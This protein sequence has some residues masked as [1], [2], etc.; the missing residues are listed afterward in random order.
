M[1]RSTWVEIDVSAL[2]HNFSLV[3]QHAGVP[4]CAVVKANG[5]GHGLVIAARAFAHD[6]AMLAVTRIEEARALRDAGIDARIFILAPVANPQE[7][8]DLVCEISVGSVDQIA[9]LPSDAR[10]HL[11]VDTGMGR[12][13]VEPN[14]AADAARAISARA[15]LSS[16]WTHFADAAGPSGKSQL[17][18]FAGMATS[19]RTVGI[20]VPVHA[21]N[22]AGTLALPGARFDMVRV[23]TLLYGQDPPG[24]RAP[25]TPRDP[26]AL[27]ARV[28]ALRT[29]PSGSPVGYGSEWRAKRPTR[30]ATLSVGYTDGFLL[31]PSART[32]SVRESARAAARI[33]ARATGIRESPRTVYFGNRRAPVVGRVGMQLITV[34]VEGIPDATEGSVARVP[35][36][37]LLVNPSIER[38]VVGDG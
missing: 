4:V 17:Q 10:A 11:I 19:L 31:E 9:S 38:V 14:E 35:G 15:T 1:D 33:A 32:E 13:G 3:S 2:K 26:F 16:V 5:Y 24:V 29:I 37:R 23:G 7:A 25:W 27:Y 21:S 8:G 6:A 22:S 20:T 30:V 12:L 28:I 36:R 34:D 18:L